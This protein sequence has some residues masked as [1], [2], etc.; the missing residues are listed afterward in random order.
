LQNQTRF[1]N[2]AL[3]KWLIPYVLVASLQYQFTKDGLNYSSPF[4]L[5][6]FRYIFVGIIFYFLGGRKIPLDRDALLVAAFS[7]ASTLPWAIGL[8]YVSPGDSAILSY[9]MPIF[10]IPIAMMVIK[11]KVFPRELLGALTG[12][13]GVIVFSLTLSHGSQLL[14]A[15]LT[16]VGA[17]FWGAYSV[18]YR[19]LRSRNPIPIFATQFL[20]GSIPGVIGSLLYPQ[21]SPGINLLVDVAYIVLFTGVVQ[22]ILWNGLLRRGRVGRITTLAFAVPA[23]TILT[24]SIRSLVP[25]SSLAVL[26]GIVMFVGIFISNWSRGDSRETE[27]STGSSAPEKTRG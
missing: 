4:V 15:S 7:S 22:F 18:Y 23:T 11:E 6:T 21:L 2:A 17:L 8:N 20:V 10:S 12:F 3:A 27:Q 24:D 26:G 13:G 16:L 9:T 14:G 1:S 25:P 5:M 19:K